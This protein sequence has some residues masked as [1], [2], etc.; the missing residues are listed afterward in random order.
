VHVSRREA[1][2]FLSFFRPEGRGLVTRRLGRF[3]LGL[4]ASP[5]YLAVHGA[6]RS[7]ADLE[8]HEFVSYID[9]LIQ[10]DAV[11]WLDEVIRE[12]RVAFHSNSMIAQMSAAAAGLGI[13]LLPFFAVDRYP[14]LT[15]VLAGEVL[16]QR[17]IW[18][19]VHRDLESVPRIEAVAGF[20]AELI[21]ADQTYLSR[22]T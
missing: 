6:P 12:P 9:D 11:R 20:L 8:R 19:S 3:G 14:D 7:T 17:D 5:A 13:V 15:R 18:L 16:V 10:V 21:D 2:V 4:F 1:D 22:A